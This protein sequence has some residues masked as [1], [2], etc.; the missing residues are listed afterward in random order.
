MKLTCLEYKLNI[1]NGCNTIEKGI[2]VVPSTL[3]TILIN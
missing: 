2:I 1:R 3:K